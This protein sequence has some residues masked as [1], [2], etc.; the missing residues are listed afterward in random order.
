MTRQ[1]AF[2]LIELMI[3]VLIVAVMLTV[4]TS[5]L[6]ALRRN[7]SSRGALD[8]YVALHANARATAVRMGRTARLRADPAARRI[9]VDVPGTTFTGTATYFQD[10]VRFTTD[11]TILC[12][13]ARGLAIKIDALTCEPPNATVVFSHANR[14][15][16]LRITMLGRVMR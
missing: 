3:A 1:H 11:R 9:W 12:F 2:S 14:S 7:A 6:M 13:D 8:Q 10:G 16:T 15:D 4:G 5:S